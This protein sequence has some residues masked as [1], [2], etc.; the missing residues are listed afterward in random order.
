MEGAILNT[1]TGPIY[2][3]KDAEIMEGSIV[4]GPLAMNEHSA[5]KLGTKVSDK[6][7]SNKAVYR[8]NLTLKFRYY[9]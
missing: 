5:L 8:M 1:N 2:V 7:E 6:L 3:A 4:R 9:L